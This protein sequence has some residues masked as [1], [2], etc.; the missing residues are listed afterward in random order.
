MDAVK[1]V[2]IWILTGVLAVLLPISIGITAAFIKKL[3]EK[4]DELITAI[5]RLNQYNAAAT[6]TMAALEE[7][8]RSI[9]HKLSQQ[10]TL[11]RT[12]ELNCKRHGNGIT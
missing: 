6:V 8:R 7:S 11:I 10:E 12:L 5:Q 9:N 2:Y 4:I 1:D 3:N